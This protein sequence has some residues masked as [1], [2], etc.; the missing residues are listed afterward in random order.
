MV[1]RY[2]DTIRW[3]QALPPVFVA[4]ALVGILLGWIPFFRGFLI[5]EI[6]L[7]SITLLSIGIKL[8]FRDR[9]IAHVLGIPA[10]IASMHISWGSGFLW[11]LAKGLIK[12]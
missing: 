8:A 6:L 1:K 7:Y 9:E 11:S 3:R 12:R 5:A 10:S 2:P 4:S